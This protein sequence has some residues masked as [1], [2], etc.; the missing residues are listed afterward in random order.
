MESLN[1]AAHGAGRAMSRKAALSSI[2]KTER[3]NYMKE[4]GISLFGGGID[5]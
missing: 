3:D 1:S 4:R 5:E 2:T